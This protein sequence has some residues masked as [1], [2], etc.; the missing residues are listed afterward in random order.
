[1]TEPDF[2]VFD[3][4]AFFGAIDKQRGHRELSWPELG[5]VTGVSPGTIK[6]FAT[7][8]TIEADG[9]LALVRWLGRPLEDFSPANAHLNSGKGPATA[10]PG[11]MLRRDTQR[12]YQALVERSE[13]D[14]V[15]LKQIAE[16]VGIS[17]AQIRGFAKG[18]RTNIRR[19]LRVLNYLEADFHGFTQT[20]RF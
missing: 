11:T 9:V 6:R 2:K 5:R 12:L 3:G 13:R 17:T 8:D 14:G 7:G 19:F 18:G 4:P 1:M 20:T 10:L 15:S 16:E